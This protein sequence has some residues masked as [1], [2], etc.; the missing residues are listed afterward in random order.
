MNEPSLHCF[1]NWIGVNIIVAIGHGRLYDVPMLMAS[2][3]TPGKEYV[4]DV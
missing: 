2:S 1:S 3:P 4:I